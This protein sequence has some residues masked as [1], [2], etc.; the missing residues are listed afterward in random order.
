M[1]CIRV[2]YF[3][4][5]RPHGCLFRPRYTYIYVCLS[6]VSPTGARRYEKKSVC[7]IEP[8]DA[9]P[10]TGRGILLIAPG[11]VQIKT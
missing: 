2:Q 1:R 7:T 8:D 11:E 5:L 9:V 4:P 6:V 10:V 3:S